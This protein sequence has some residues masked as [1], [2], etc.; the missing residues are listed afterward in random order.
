MPVGPG[1]QPTEAHPNETGPAEADRLRAVLAAMTAAHARAEARAT[2]AARIIA[3]LRAEVALLS[4]ARN[5]AEKARNF[6]QEAAMSQHGELIRLRA[7]TGIMPEAPP[8]LSP[9]PSPPPPPPPIPFDEAW[10]LA[11]YG[12]VKAAVAA[13][14]FPS[15]H[16]HYL[17]HGRA[18]GRQPLPK[19]P[20]ARRG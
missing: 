15:G 16:D 3:T 8:V 4:A 17:Q 7:K 11:T 19:P 20:K 13:E 10:Y 18:E 1:A 14:I 12:D 2:R 5:A 9:A 6:A